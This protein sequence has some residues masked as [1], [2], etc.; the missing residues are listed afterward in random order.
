MPI[1]GGHAWP[2][3][4]Y[5]P[6][7]APLEFDG[8]PT[9]EELDLLAVALA[10][11]KATDQRAGQGST[12]AVHLQLAGHHANVGGKHREVVSRLTKKE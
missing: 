5:G 7:L 8:P 1:K 3:V 11:Q 6:T 10:Q 4:R 9:A 2:I 12:V